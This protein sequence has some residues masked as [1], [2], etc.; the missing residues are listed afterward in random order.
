MPR[1]CG[2]CGAST[3]EI[4]LKVS[5][6]D[7]RKIAMELDELLQSGELVVCE[8]CT[9]RLAGKMYR[10]KLALG[11]N[12]DSSDEEL[13]EQMITMVDFVHSEPP[14][15]DW[16]ASLPSERSNSMK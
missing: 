8:S 7:D 11:L 12:P 5:D 3:D 16:E 14:K 4:A 10:L 15:R 1:N 6:I 13:A 2:W 9:A